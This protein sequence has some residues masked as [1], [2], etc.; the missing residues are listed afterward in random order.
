V[1]FPHDLATEIAE[2]VAQLL[3]ISLHLASA[4]RFGRS[5]F[6]GLRYRGRDALGEKRRARMLYKRRS[7]NRETFTIIRAAKNRLFSTPKAV[8]ATNR[9]TVELVLT[10]RELLIAEFARCYARVPDGPN[11]SISASVFH[12]RKAQWAYW[13]A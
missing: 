12:S 1:P 10:R 4:P 5:S 8:L 2:A 7:R 13:A 11:R 3:R 9:L 6:Q